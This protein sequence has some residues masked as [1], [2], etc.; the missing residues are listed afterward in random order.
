MARRPTREATGSPGGFGSNSG[1]SVPVETPT[2]TDPHGPGYEETPS[3]HEEDRGPEGNPADEAES[4][5]QPK[6]NPRHGEGADVP[7]SGATPAPDAGVQ[8]SRSVYARSGRAGTGTKSQPIQS[9]ALQVV[10]NKSNGEIRIGEWLGLMTRQ[11]RDNAPLGAL[12]DVRNLVLNKKTGALTSRVGGFRSHQ[13]LYASDYSGD[14][15]VSANDYLFVLDTETPSVQTHTLQAC[16]DA[17]ANKA[18]LQNPF[19][20]NSSSAESGAV[21]WGER[22]SGITI[23]GIASSTSVSFV[24]GET[25]ANYYKYWILYNSTRSDAVFVTASSKVTTTTTLTILEDG[26]DDWIEGDTIILYRHFHDNLGFAPTYGITGAPTAIQQG[27]AILFSGGR[28]SNVGCKLIWSGYISKTFFAGATRTLAF[29]GTYVTEAEIKS[30][31]GVSP[32]NA[33]TYVPTIALDEN[34]RWFHAFVIEDEEGQRSQLIKAGTNYTAISGTQGMSTT[35]RCT[36]QINKRIRKIYHFAG[37]TTDT[38]ATS[39]E[40]EQYFLIGEND[41]LASGWTYTD[42]TTEPGYWS[43]EFQVSGTEW[44]ARGEDLTSFLGHSEANNTTVSCSLIERVNNRTFVADYYDYTAGAS[45]QD[46]IR[47]SPVAGNGVH[48]TNVLPDI[49]DLTQ[50]DVGPGDSA[51]IRGIKQWE[52]KLFIIKDNSCYYI[53]VFGESI[54]WDLVTVTQI[55]SGTAST[56][57][58]TPYGIVFAK[59]GEDVYL[60]D[61]T[62]VLPVA[63]NIL[64]TIQGITMGPAWYDAKTKTYNISD[65]AGSRTTWYSMSF[66]LTFDGGF[67]WTKH[68]AATDSNLVDIANVSALST[69]IPTIFLIAQS[70]ANNGFFWYTESTDDDTENFNCYFKTAP[71]VIDEKNIAA[72]N[73][74]HLALESIAGATG[75]LDMKAT[76]AGAQG[77]TAKTWSNVSKSE[78]LHRRG[79]SPLGGANRGRRIEFEFN[80]N[81]TPATFTGL[82]VNEFGIDYEVLPLTGDSVKTS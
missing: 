71:I 8:T 33:T 49:D 63:Y 1:T 65:T 17:S 79:L 9:T 37:Q 46:S 60:Y 74:M 10:G 26:P 2:Y 77:S 43:K 34:F 39:L 80:V 62:R 27:Q 36:S 53:R 40:Y 78:T 42:A 5:P 61:G 31:A 48:Q 47:Y 44:N 72:F 66:D 35:V 32:Q 29:T 38:S 50:T 30:T 11:S 67:V 4:K 59:S 57:V 45:L 14:F 7:P 64:P 82:Q 3:T 75:T 18:I 55:G 54:D 20:P 56:I 23:S 58:S 69:T 19:F 52:D 15:S 16:R 76:P 6:Y 70:G 73:Q 22:L 13:A 21:K 12:A 28:S 41:L 68:V 81:A 25:I 51:V 24:G